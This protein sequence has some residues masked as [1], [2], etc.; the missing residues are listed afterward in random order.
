MHQ[1]TL[2]ANQLERSSAEKQLRIP[3]QHQDKHEPAMRPCSGDGQHHSGLHWKSIASR[4]REVI[5]P[6][7]LST[8]EATSGC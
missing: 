4:S 8:G 3:G 7:C 1:Y 6:L 5:S 2:G